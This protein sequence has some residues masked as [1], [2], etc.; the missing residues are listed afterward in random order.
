MDAAC[1]SKPDGSDETSVDRGG[2]MVCWV[3]RGLLIDRICV[4]VPTEFLVRD[5]WS[6][7]IALSTNR[8]RP[9]DI[10]RS[11]SHIYNYQRGELLKQDRPF[12]TKEPLMGALDSRS[13]RRNI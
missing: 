4:C 8:D 11:C 13:P 10:E 9:G 2:A 6:L 3:D 5:Q 7:R 1:D 12:T